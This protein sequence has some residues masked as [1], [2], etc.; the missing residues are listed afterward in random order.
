MNIKQTSPLGDGRLIWAYLLGL[1]GVVGFG[2][3][4]PVTR[5]ALEDF[6]PGFLTLARALLATVFAILFLFIARK[7][8]A[9]ENNALIF[10]AGIFMIFAFPGFMAIAMQTVPASHGGVVLG[11][12]PLATAILAR[13]IA[14]EIPS[15]R[16][17]ILSILGGLIVVIYT[18]I[19]ADQA[20]TTGISAGDIW[21]I[22]AGISASVG[23]V[24]FG[25]LSR[26][27]AGWEIISR[28]L[29]L[30]LPLILAGTWWFYQPDFNNASA[31]GWIALVYLGSTSM[32]LAFIVWNMAL[33]MGGIA[34]IG[35]MQLLQTFVTLIVAAFLLNEPIDLLTVATAIVITAIIAATRKP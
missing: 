30:N 4:L 13:L 18:F 19:T 12:L 2:A 21:L 8:L 17:W 11:F 15:T 24:I 6:T 14:D 20:G 5:L 34:R 33:A 16:F 31:T 32:F 9:H 7:R 28:A 35:Q 27:T 23:Y 3:T 22:V 25:K 29:L 10:L 1:V 26:N